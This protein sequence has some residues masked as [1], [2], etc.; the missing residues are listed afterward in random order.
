MALNFRV[1]RSRP[2]SL[3][4]VE[5]ATLVAVHPD[6]AK[7]VPK[8][9][10]KRVGVAA[11]A[12]KQGASW[13]RPFVP[14]Q[15]NAAQQLKP[16][17]VR[18]LAERAASSLA[19]Q[20][21]ATPADIELALRRQGI[22][23]VEPFSPGKPLVP[24]YGYGRRPRTYDYRVGRNITTETRPD[25]IPFATLQQVGGIAGVSRPGGQLLL[26]LLVNTHM[27]DHA[28]LV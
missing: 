8:A 1:W 15:R 9:L 18:A 19:P 7:E 22:D 4:E 16:I 24:Y 6:R 26:K 27:V 13:T 3:E 21:P 12:I 28:P 23:W 2:L 11:D 14:G 17:Q 5:L 10:Q 20:S 25:R